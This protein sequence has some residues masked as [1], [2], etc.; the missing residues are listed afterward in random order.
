M[1]LDNL[2]KGFFQLSKTTFDFSYDMDPSMTWALKL[3]QMVEKGLV[4][5]RNVA[6]E[7]KKQ[8]VNYNV[9]P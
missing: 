8:K 3:K 6:G 1:T 5:Y 4:P 7:I 9:F 2:A